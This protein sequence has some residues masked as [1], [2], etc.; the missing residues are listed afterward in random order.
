MQAAMQKLEGL[1]R[2]AMQTYNMVQKGDVVCVG[3][4]GG[5]DSIA[6]AV[7][8]QNLSRYYDVPYTIHALTLDPCFKGVETDYTPVSELFASRGIPYTIRRTNIGSVVFDIRKESNPCALCAKLRRGELHTT[9]RGLGCNKVATG[10]HL[11]DAVQT[12]YMNLFRGGRIGCFS[13]VTWLSRKEIT[14][15]RPMVLAAEQDVINAVNSLALPVVKSTCPVDGNTERANAK[16]FVNARSEMD[17]AFRQK[18]L[19]ALQKAGI[20]GWGVGGCA[21]CMDEEDV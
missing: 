18:T 5:K 8:L 17:A 1:M 7:A 20:N 4:S 14:L 12:F 21:P 3:V 15:I 6:L 13:P 16:V 2:K 10:H 11:D 9:A 19:G